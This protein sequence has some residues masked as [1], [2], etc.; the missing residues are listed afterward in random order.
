MCVCA[1]CLMCE[2][3]CVGGVHVCVFAMPDVYVS[4]MLD[5]CMCGDGAWGCVRVRAPCLMCECVYWSCTCVCFM[6]DVC[7][8]YMPDVCVCVVVVYMCVCVR[9]RATLHVCVP[10]MLEV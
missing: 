7:V 5:V 6:L 4:Y 8:P 2:C 3:M 1:P 10:Y 9:V